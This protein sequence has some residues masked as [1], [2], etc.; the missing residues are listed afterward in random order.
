MTKKMILGLMMVIGIAAF[1]TPVFGQGDR[2]RSPIGISD[3]VRVPNPRV[4]TL[5]CCRCLEGSNTLDLS[6][7]AGSAWT[8]NSVPVSI[9][10]SPTVAWNIP[11]SGAKWVSANVSGNSGSTND[12]VYKLK[13]VVPNCSISQDIRLTGTL[14]ADN[15]V[16]AFLD[17]TQISTCSGSYCFKAGSTAPPPFNVAVGPGSHELIVRVKD[18][19]GLTGMFVNAKLVGKC[20]TKLTKD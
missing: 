9:V 8:V 10:T 6:T 18:E 12:Y 17:S 3:A 11:T 2:E 4:P 15:N 13:F 19:G 14:G 7:I 16:Q 20:S 1:M 5:A